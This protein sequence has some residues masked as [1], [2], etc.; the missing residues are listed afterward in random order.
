[1]QYEELKN[2]EITFDITNFIVFDYA[3]TW[4]LDL[5][6]VRDKRPCSLDI[7]V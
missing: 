6:I 5:L 3:A 2:D 4:Q 1:M 7:F